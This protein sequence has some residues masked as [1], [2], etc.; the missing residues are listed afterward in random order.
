MMGLV[1]ALTTTITRPFSLR[2]LL[3]RIR[4]VLRRQR[5][6]ISHGRPEGVRRTKVSLFLDRRRAA[7][8]SRA[9]S[10]CCLAMLASG[11]D[12][13]GG[14]G[15]AEG[16][17]DPGPGDG[18]G[19]GPGDQEAHAQVRRRRARARG[20]SH[21]YE[22]ATRRGTRFRSRCCFQC[23]GADRCMSAAAVSQSPHIPKSR[24]SGRLRRAVEENVLERFLELRLGLGALARQAR[25]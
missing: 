20:A 16:A 14:G 1:W 5:R 18:G 4:A 23:L 7:D 2:E 9:Y 25:G 19:P 10:L 11:G 22:R 24:A 12:R 15:Q 8:I 6:A 13:G 17:G 21:A 3:A